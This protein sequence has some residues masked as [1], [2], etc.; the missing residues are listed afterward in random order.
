MIILGGIGSLRGAVIGAVAFTLLKEFY[1]SEAL[2][3]AAGRALA[4]DAGLHDHRLRRLAAEGPDR[5][6]ALAQARM[7]ARGTTRMAE[8]LLRAAVADAPLRRADRGRTRVSL[9]LQRGELHAVIGTNGAGKS[10]LINMLS[11]ELPATSGRIELAGADITAWSQPRRARA[12]IG[13]SY[14]RT[15]I[16]PT[17][18]V[19]E[20]ARLCAQARTAAAVGAV[21]VGGALRAPAATRPRGRS[22]PP[23]WPTCRSAWPALLSHGQQRQL[24]IA[25]CLA[26]RAARAAARRAAG[27]HGRRGDRA[28]ARAADRH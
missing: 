7:A 16:F 24:E 9:A 8:P 1:Q 26:T 11:G 28:H 13:R 23:A 21:A 19:F 12:G 3:G 27:R 18:S 5:P 25:M 14:Q 2:L 15:T 20:N 22:P 6:G 4:A 10:T 17:L